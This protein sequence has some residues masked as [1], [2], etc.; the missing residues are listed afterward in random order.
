MASNIHVAIAARKASLDNS[1]NLANG[2]FLDLYTTPQ[3]ANA[4]TAVGAQTLVASF[5]LPN[6]AFSAAA[7]ASGATATKT[8]NAVANVN[9]SNT[10]SPVW[11]RIFQSDHTTA[12]IDGSAGIAGTDAILNVAT[13]TSGDLVVLVSCVFNMVA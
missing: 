3:P 7:G 8:M 2:G 10:G 4:D 11:F 6:P 9:A 12:V 13:F 1:L 5:A